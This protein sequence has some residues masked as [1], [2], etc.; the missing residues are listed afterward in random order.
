[1]TA[2]ASP[3]AG[4]SRLIGNETL[5][6][7]Q[8][9]GRRRALLVSFVVMHAITF[10]GI[11]LLIGGG[12]RHHPSP[13]SHPACPAGLRRRADCRHAGQRRHRRGDQRRHPR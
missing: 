9:A 13:S 10:L 6:G 1:M 12:H 7:L 5:K 11:R 4:S 8:L 3:T 2:I